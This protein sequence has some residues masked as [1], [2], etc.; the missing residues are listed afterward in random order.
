V[1]GLAQ[2]ASLGELARSQHGLFTRAQARSLGFS[3][4]T[5]RRRTTAGAWV[6]VDANV[7][8]P[9]SVPG[10]WLVDLMAA[11]L[12]AG[13]EALASHRSAAALH[14]LEGL[15]PGLVEITAPRWHR[16]PRDVD[17]HESTDLSLEDYDLVRGIPCTSPVRTIVDLGAVVPIDVLETAL[18]DGLRRR[19][20]TLDD[21][22]R[23]R[24]EVARRGRNG[25]GPIRAILAERPVGEA[26]AHSGFESRLSRVLTRAG[27]P[28]PVRQHR[29]YDGELFIA[30]L[31]LSYPDVLVGLEAD[32]E[33]WHMSRKRFT[34]DRTRRNKLEAIG[35]RILQFTYQHLRFHHDHIFATVERAIAEQTKRLQSASVGDQI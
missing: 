8:R 9:A 20:Y 7:Y 2:D 23:R 32:S 19:L 28:R 12:T 16:R 18:D 26:V 30:Q 14:R 10:S 22:D 1:V 13:P 17:L 24:R 5:I 35:W 34:D 15:A 31:D 11:C 3:D 27:F 33:A 6:R 25:A 21:I 29:V 4:A